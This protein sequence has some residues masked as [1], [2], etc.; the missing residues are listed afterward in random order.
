MLQVFSRQHCSNGLAQSNVAS[1][2]AATAG[3]FTPL[4]TSGTGK[5]V[6]GD[7]CTYSL[8]TLPAITGVDSYSGVYCAQ[9]I[10]PQSG[11]V[12]TQNICSISAYLSGLPDGSVLMPFWT[13]KN[14][15]SGPVMPCDSDVKFIPTEVSGANGAVSFET[16]FPVPNTSALNAPYYFGLAVMARFGAAG[17]KILGAISLRQVKSEF[18][19][20]QPNK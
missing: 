6:G 19:V 11:Y 15:A 8:M 18:A 1:T 13:T 12:G 10:I 17:A 16:C 9:Q 5:A 20:F 14:L 4:R 7:D 2:A 3:Q